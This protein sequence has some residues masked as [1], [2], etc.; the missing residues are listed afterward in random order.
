VG[1][2]ILAE[3]RTGSAAAVQRFRS[4]VQGLSAIAAEDSSLTILQ[5][6]LANLV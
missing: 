6:V 1:I 2:V 4:S 3:A 5:V